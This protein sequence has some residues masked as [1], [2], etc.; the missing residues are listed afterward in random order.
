MN[1]REN[2]DNLRGDNADLGNA[3]NASNANDR[4]QSSNAGQ[5]GDSADQRA[6]GAHG[7]G[8]GE[9][10]LTVDAP[11]QPEHADGSDRGGSSTWGSEG[12]GGSV[13]DKRKPS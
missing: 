2:E 13:I 8:H 3:S 10:Q 7:R 9:E 6:H 1:M 5:A 4:P 11:V 12:S